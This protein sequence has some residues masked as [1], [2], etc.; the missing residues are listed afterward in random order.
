[1]VENS[2]LLTATQDMAMYCILKASAFS[3]AE[4]FKFII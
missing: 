4:A 2:S 1:M 3:I